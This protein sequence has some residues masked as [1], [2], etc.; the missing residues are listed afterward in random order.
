M[1]NIF[2]IL[3]IFSALKLFS[4]DS[5]TFEYVDKVTYDY[6]RTGNW[7]DLV[8]I[9]EKAEKQGIDYYYLNYRMGVSWYMREDYMLSAHYFEKALEQNQGALTDSFFVTLLMNDYLQTKRFAKAELLK[10]YHPRDYMRNRKYTKFVSQIYAEGGKAL[11]NNINNKAFTERKYYYFKEIN[12]FKDLSYINTDIQ[13]YIS[14]Y[15]KYQVAF[16]GLSISRFMF[17]KEFPDTFQQDYVINQSYIYS[18]LNFNYKNFYFNPAINLPGYSSKELQITGTDSIYGR[19]IY[20][21]VSIRDRNVVLSLRAGMNFRRL[22]FGLTG[23]YSDIKGNNQM[24]LGAEVVYFP[25]GNLNTYLI[26]QL[27]TR[28]ENNVAYLVLRQ[29]F[30]MRFAPFLWGEMRLT[31][32]DMRNFNADNGYYVY[33]TYDNLKSLTDISLI[34]VVTE[35]LQLNFVFQHV[36]KENSVITYPS[37]FNPVLETTDYYFQQINLIGGI[38]WNF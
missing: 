20:D 11:A 22:K 5:L 14:P 3:L 32:G 16:S 10:I 7:I 13:G 38:Q 36:L 29:K 9:G 17:F 26:T 31:L 35:N 6:Y 37:K 19:N 21:T 25:G 23:S 34:F 18:G 28:W 27:T 33:N 8:I 2:F 30:G 4:Q 24:Q 12:Q 15:M 1:R